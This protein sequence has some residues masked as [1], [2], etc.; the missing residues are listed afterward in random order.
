MTTPSKAQAIAEEDR[1]V[2]NH[3]MT[4]LTDEW[5]RLGDSNT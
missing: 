1:K 5:C 4:E 3:N 2:N